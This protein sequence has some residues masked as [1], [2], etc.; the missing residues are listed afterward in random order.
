VKTLTEQHKALAANLAHFKGMDVTRMYR[1][2][3]VPYHPGALKYYKEHGV[4]ETE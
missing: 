3:P 4:K 2:L 1:R